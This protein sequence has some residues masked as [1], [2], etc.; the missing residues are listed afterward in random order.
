[1]SLPG[2]VQGAIS[3]VPGFDCDTALSADR[4]RQFFAQG[5][6]FCLRYL[7]RRHASAQDLT[8]VEATGI[9]S[10]GL[11]LMPVQH[12][13]KHGWSPNQVLGQQDGQEA[14]A[15]AKTVGFPDRVSLWC[16]LEGVNSSAEAQNVIDYCEAW[17]EAVIA[18]GYIPGLYVGAG[19]LLT[20][21]QL[22][23][24]PFQH[25]WR[26]RSQ[27]P[28]IPNRGYQ[29]IQLAPSIQINGVWIDLDV[30]Q[31]DQKGGAAQWLRVN[32]AILG[33]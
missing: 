4:A 10:S 15:S 18:A 3:S 5:Y 20:G 6:K 2:D 32:T 8:E 23:D 29:V 25:Y 30:A 12:A 7:S 31:T 16:D 9:L 14:S 28:D 21:Q 13:R 22:Y 26:S 33:E 19:A 27:V 11:A 17:Y 24:L 1:M